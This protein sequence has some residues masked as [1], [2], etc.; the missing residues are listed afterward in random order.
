M[1]YNLPQHSELS[2]VYSIKIIPKKKADY[3]VIKLH[4]VTRKFQSIDDLKKAVVDGCKE[5]VSLESFGFIE[6]GHG[7]KGKQRWLSSNDD[8]KD[9]YSSHEGKKEILLWCYIDQGQKRRAQ[10]PGDAAEVHKRSRYDKHLDKMTEVEEVE[11]KLREKHPDGPYS[12]E[13][14]R[15]WAHLIQ[16]KKHSSYDVPPNK[17]FWKVTR[18]KQKLLSSTDT[19]ITVS[20]SKRVNLRGQCVQQLLQLHELLEKGGISKEQY[21]EMRGTIMD[22]VK[23]Y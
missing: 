20:P 4:G 6:P 8:L 9:M 2:L 18:S 12:E 13:Q 16:M 15:S 19:E 21:D 1:N 7:A 3:S 10:S 14:L 23:K 5:K 17:P 11:E 22:E